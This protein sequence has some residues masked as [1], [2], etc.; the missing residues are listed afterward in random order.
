M[1]TLKVRTAALDHVDQLPAVVRAVATAVKDY[2][3]AKAGYVYQDGIGGFT[4]NFDRADGGVV[5]E[6]SMSKPR[7]KRRA[8]AKRR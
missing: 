3:H 4:T 6:W 7:A 8:T 2:N 5:A 1:F